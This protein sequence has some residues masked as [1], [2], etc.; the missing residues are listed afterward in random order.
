MC[1]LAAID[2]SAKDDAVIAPVTRLA[3]A[4]EA[5]VVLLNVFSPWVDTVFS[6]V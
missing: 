5:G 3:K 1:F 4:A 2:Q 6:K